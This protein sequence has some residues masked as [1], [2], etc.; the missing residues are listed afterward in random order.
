M[1]KGMDADAVSKP[2]AARGKP[3]AAAGFPQAGKSYGQHRIHCINIGPY[4]KQRDIWR[5]G[6]SNDV[7]YVKP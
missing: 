2:S 4:T 3:E 6:D 5:T 7:P 1:R